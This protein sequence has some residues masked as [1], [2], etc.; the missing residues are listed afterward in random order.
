MSANID[1]TGK[2]KSL[3]CANAD[4]IA[5]MY[6]KGDQTILNFK[7][8]EEVTCGARPEH[9]RNEEIVVSEMKN[10]KLITYWEKVYK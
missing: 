7:T 10:D 6:R 8:N 3:I 9:L 1:L 2:I 4:A 5:Y